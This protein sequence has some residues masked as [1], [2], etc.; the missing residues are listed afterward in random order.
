MQ[1]LHYII[2]I[3]PAS[4][5]N[6]KEAIVRSVKKYP[7]PC[8]WCQTESGIQPKPEESHG[9]CRRHELLM[10][11]DMQE[12]SLDEMEELQVLLDVRAVT[13]S[14]FNPLVIISAGLRRVG[15]WLISDEGSAVMTSLILSAA[16]IIGVSALADWIARGFEI[17]RR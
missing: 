5:R 11:S 7:T 3:T 4:H 8:A 14:R 17:I 13:W 9:I 16:A 2:S 6:L 12:I 1:L 10:L 15:S